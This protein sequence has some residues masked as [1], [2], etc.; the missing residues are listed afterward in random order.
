MEFTSHYIKEMY[1]ITNIKEINHEI[2]TKRYAFPLVADID[3][4]KFCFV[5]VK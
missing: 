2:K 4:A 1:V 3:A 5:N